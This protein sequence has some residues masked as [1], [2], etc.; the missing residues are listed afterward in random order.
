MVEILL[1][2]NI[3]NQSIKETEIEVHI[4]S[5]AHQK[6]KS[7]LINDSK[8]KGCYKGEDQFVISVIDKW[9]K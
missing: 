7:I 8:V 9:K 2:C 1:R 6:K 5:Q 4:C 3:C